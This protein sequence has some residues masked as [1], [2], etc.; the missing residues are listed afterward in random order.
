MHKQI[1]EHIGFAWSGRWF[2]IKKNICAFSDIEKNLAKKW[3]SHV[4][5]CW[6]TSRYFSRPGS[7]MQIIPRIHMKI[8]KLK[9][10][11]SY[12]DLNM[13]VKMYQSFCLK[14]CWLAPKFSDG[15]QPDYTSGNLSEV[16]RFTLCKPTYCRPLRKSFS[17][18]EPEFPQV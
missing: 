8:Y 2:L 5:K 17:F 18:F 16:P 3:I 15:G 14:F 11:N 1:D 12:V 10:C 13:K 6:F 9:I 4:L 7:N